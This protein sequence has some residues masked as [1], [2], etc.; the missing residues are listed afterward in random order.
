MALITRVQRTLVLLAATLAVS[1]VSAMADDLTIDDFRSS[2]E[3]SWRF[4]ADTVMG[5]VSSGGVAFGSEAGDVH[6][7]LTGIVSTANNGGF[8]QARR[9]LAAQ[10]PTGATGIRLTARGNNQRYY[11]HLRTSGTVLPWQ[12]YQ[13]GFDVSGEWQE[14]RLPL[15][16]FQRSGRML[17]E[18][19][20]AASLKS[21]AIVAYGRDHKADVQVREIGFY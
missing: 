14:F 18:V 21:V 9:Q 13:A 16:Q 19:P 7:H 12:Y 15:N 2:P 1:G 6:I 5:G 11:I 8:I 17:A 4:V 20:A 10:P 3:G